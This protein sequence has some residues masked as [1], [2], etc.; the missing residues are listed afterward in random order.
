MCQE[1]TE[2]KQKRD[3]KNY[4]MKFYIQ[5]SVLALHASRGLSRAK[6][7]TFVNEE[8]IGR[9]RGIAGRLCAENALLFKIN[10]LL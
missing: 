7:E 6:A 5:F 1:R 8:D 4:I 2:K 9:H 10:Y 3:A